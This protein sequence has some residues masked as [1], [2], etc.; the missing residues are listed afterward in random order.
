MLVVGDVKGRANFLFSEVRGRIS[1]SACSVEG[2]RPL[3]YLAVQDEARVRQAYAGSVH[4]GTLQRNA[5]HYGMS[6]IGRRALPPGFSSGWRHDAV[7]YDTWREDLRKL[8]RLR[9][10]ELDD[11]TADIVAA[12]AGIAALRSAPPAGPP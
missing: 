2:S 9:D 12:A 8:Q 3:P 10:S 4:P 7:R 1:T 5:N 11:G 6:S